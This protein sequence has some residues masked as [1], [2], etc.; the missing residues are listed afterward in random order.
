MNRDCRA[1]KFDCFGEQYPLP[2]ERAF[3]LRVADVRTI[4]PRHIEAAADIDQD[5][6]YQCDST[7]LKYSIRDD[8]PYCLIAGDRHSPIYVRT[9]GQCSI[10]YQTNDTVPGKI[11]RYLMSDLVTRVIGN[12]YRHWDYDLAQH[13]EPGERGPGENGAPR[14]TANPRNFNLVDLAD[15][16]LGT[17][18]TYIQDNTRPTNMHRTRLHPISNGIFTEDEGEI[19]DT[20]FMEMYVAQFKKDYT[21]KELHANIVKENHV[22]THVL[23]FIYKYIYLVRLPP[24]ADLEEGEIPTPTTNPIVFQ[25]RLP[26]PIPPHA[27]GTAKKRGTQI[28]SAPRTRSAR[29]QRSRKGGSGISGIPLQSFDE[30]L[31]YIESK[32]YKSFDDIKTLQSQS[33]ISSDEGE[34]LVGYAVSYKIAPLDANLNYKDQ[35]ESVIKSKNIHALYTILDSESKCTY[36]LLH[37]VPT[38]SGGSGGGRRKRAVKSKK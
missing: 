3:E 37:I 33:K 12:Y 34:E 38:G 15:T 11:V 36:V 10:P 24:Q 22:P 9:I 7:V 4:L 32:K 21:V 8:A 30:L 31:K 20:S 23:E 25:G 16:V 1:T 17:H 2:P 19:I 28:R 26:E 13:I 29:A 27:G 35:I 5:H 18:Y 6:V 14:I